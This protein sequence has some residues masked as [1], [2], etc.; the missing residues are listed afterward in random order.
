MSFYVAVFRIRIHF[1]AD[2][3]SGPSQAAFR[4]ESRG[5]NLPRRI[6]KKISNESL[7][8]KLKYFCQ[9]IPVLSSLQER[10]FS[11]LDLDP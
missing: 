4:S 3:D 8:K 11:L 6:Y 5:K 10:G 7:T 9:Q 1:N 2:P